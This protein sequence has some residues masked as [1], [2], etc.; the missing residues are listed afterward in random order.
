VWGYA[1]DPLSNFRV[2]IDR[3]TGTMFLSDYQL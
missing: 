2:L 3:Q 1:D